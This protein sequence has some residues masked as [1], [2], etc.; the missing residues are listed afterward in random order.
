[1]SIRQQDGEL[2]LD[3]GMIMCFDMNAVVE[4]EIVTNGGNIFEAIDDMQ[5]KLSFRVMRDMYYAC[6]KAN[7]PDMTVVEAG[8]IAG[9]YPEA[10]TKV[11]LMAMP[12]PEEGDDKS[13]SEDTKKK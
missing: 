9:K 8:K 11:I 4:Y 10:L 7:Q 5:E 12:L 2:K 13:D 1:M 3:N 6:L